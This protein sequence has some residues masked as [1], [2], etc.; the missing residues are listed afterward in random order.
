MRPFLQPF[1]A[2]T[3]SRRAWLVLAALGAGV[4][5]PARAQPRH[6]PPWPADGLR[7]PRDHGAHPQ[8]RIEWWYLTGHLRDGAGADHGFQITFFRSRVEAAQSLHSA[9]AARQLVFAHAALSEVRTATLH[10]A[11]RIARAGFGVAEAA[12]GDARL[13]L[14]GWTL[15]RENGEAA[16]PGEVWRITAAAGDFALALR[17]RPTQPLLL[18]GDAGWSRKGPTPQNASCYYSL[19]QLETRGE[20]TLEGRRV[21][22]QGRAWLDHEWSDALLPEGAVGWDWIGMNLRDGRALTAF[23][24]RD[25]NGGTLW[26]GGSWRRAA[27]ADPQVFPAD[28]VVFT[29]GRRWRSPRSGAQYPVQWT[30]QTPAGRFTVSAVFD[31]QELDGRGSTG[32]IYWEGLSTLR[33]AGGALLGHGYLEMTGYAA[34][35]RL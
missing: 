4:A 34:P 30:V 31:A 32:S 27:A 5:P 2:H 35:L 20:L 17:A 9:F 21:S 16:A 7:F 10:H 25:A 33:D 1:H 13:N 12:V 29:P 14:R 24:L 19:P 22:V 3:L 23:R 28:A 6:P 15:Q 26:A 11:Q 18:Q 8:S